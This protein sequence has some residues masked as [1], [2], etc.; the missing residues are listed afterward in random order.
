M[1]RSRAWR[2]AAVGVFAKDPERTAAAVVALG[3][4]LAVAAVLLGGLVPG[5][6]GRL[7]ATLYPI[8]VLLPALGLGIL[9]LAAWWLWS[10]R[11]SDVPEI[12]RESPAASGAMRAPTPVGR[13]ADRTLEM[14][15]D[16]R[17]SCKES[18]SARDVRERLTASAVRVVRVKRGLA[19]G[20]ARERVRTGEW[21]DDPVAAAFLAADRSQPPVERLRGA[22][23]PGAAYHRRVRRTVAAIEAIDRSDDAPGPQHA[24]VSR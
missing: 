22:V 13:E 18:R 24:E 5:V 4:A 12:R 1:T 9:G 3:T 16:A 10:A 6:S 17:Y 20:A 11:G 14:A 19:A 7:A 23:D 15:A 21:T 8:A 2:A